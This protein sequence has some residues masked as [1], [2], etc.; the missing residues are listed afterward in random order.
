[1]AAQNSSQPPYEACLIANL[2]SDVQH[3]ILNIGNYVIRPLSFIL[4]FLSFVFNMLVIIAVARTRSLQYPAMVMMCSLAV[5]D[6]IFSLHSLYTY[7]E[8]F[9]DQHMCQISHPLQASFSILCGLT[10]LGNLAIISRDRYVAVRRPVWYRNYMK[11]SRA[12]KIVCI[13]WLTSVISV[14]VINLS[15]S[16]GGIYRL[17][18]VIFSVF[19]FA[20]YV[21]VVMFCYLSIYFRKTMIENQ[22]DALLR[23]EKRLANT[24]AGILLIFLLTYF[25]AFLFPTVLFAKGFKN[26]L[27]FR[28]F[29]MIFFQLNGVLN[30]LLNFGRSTKMRKAIKDLFKCLPKVQPDS[31]VKNTSNNSSKNHNHFH[32]TGITVM[33]PKSTNNTDSAIASADD[34]WEQR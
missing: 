32:T 5:T 24:V 22:N 21:I 17:L 2:P 31:C 8:M 18:G 12:F 13:S 27:P 6:V 7:I 26:F 23:K 3:Q 1:M 29:Y 10:T 34:V 30:P 14:L 19:I 25:P 28:P 9:T 33:T 11:N 15:V 16:L 20:I 4:A